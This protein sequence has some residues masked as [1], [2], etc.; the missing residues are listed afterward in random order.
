M[1]YT[2]TGTVPAQ[3]L[4]LF[5]SAQGSSERF[6]LLSANGND[7][8]YFRIHRR[9]RVRLLQ[10]R[11]LAWSLELGT[12]SDLH[13]ECNFRP[14]GETFDLSQSGS[15]PSLAGAHRTVSVPD[16]A[17]PKRTKPYPALIFIDGFNCSTPSFMSLSIKLSLIHI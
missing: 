6:S 13:S 17:E 2:V 3:T 8:C 15:F 5:P 12:K 10:R 16:K 4:K 1:R 14:N 11:P 9:A 7:V